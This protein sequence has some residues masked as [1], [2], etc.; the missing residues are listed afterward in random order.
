VPIAVHVPDLDALTRQIPAADDRSWIPS[1]QPDLEL[2]GA[3]VRLG[4][5]RGDE[6]LEG[7]VFR[8]VEHERGPF[9]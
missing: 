3:P 4:H 5:H 6:R 8:R 7:A 9:F 1:A 2:L